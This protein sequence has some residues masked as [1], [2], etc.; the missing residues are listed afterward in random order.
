MLEKDLQKAIVDYLRFKGA[1]FYAPINENPHSHFNRMGAILNERLAKKMGKRAG[2]SDLVIFGKKQILFL[3]LKRNSKNKPTKNQIEF[4]ENVNKFDYAV[5]K[6]AYSFEE[7]KNLIDEY[8]K[9]FQNL[10]N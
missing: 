9:W 5:G 7:A 2:V 6:V 1:F 4:L 10:I 8:L 3:E